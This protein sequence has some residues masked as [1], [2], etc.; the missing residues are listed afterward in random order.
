MFRMRPCIIADS[1]NIRRGKAWSSIGV[2]H[3]LT[4][5]MPM[6]GSSQYQN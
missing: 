5:K 2:E 3:L 1:E 4:N 6:S